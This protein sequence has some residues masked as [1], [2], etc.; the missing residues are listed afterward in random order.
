VL[1]PGSI[2][3]PGTMHK[4]NVANNPNLLS[5]KVL[6]GSYSKGLAAYL[7]KFN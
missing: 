5:N 7:V 1:D 2:P 4:Q 6:M 3:V